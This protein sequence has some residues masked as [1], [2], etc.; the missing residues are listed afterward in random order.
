MSP[1]PAARLAAGALLAGLLL[2][3]T[4]SPAAAGRMP[5]EMTATDPDR[6]SLPTAL[7]AYYVSVLR[8]AYNSGTLSPRSTPIILFPL[9]G[10]PLGRRST[11]A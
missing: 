1:P 7:D 3:A 10:T 8:T 9:P 4:A 2:A 11:T 5:L 6:S